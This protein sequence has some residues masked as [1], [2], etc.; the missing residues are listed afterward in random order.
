M[1]TDKGVLEYLEAGEFAALSDSEKSDYY[2]SLA[3][4]RRNALTADAKEA[5]AAAYNE[6]GKYRSAAHFASERK[7]EAA[8]QREA[9][10][11]YMAERKKKG[12][13]VIAIICAVLF[14]LIAAV[15]AVSM[16]D[17]KGK[18]YAKA[19]ELYNAGKYSEAMVIFETIRNYEDS[20]LY[21]SSINGMIMTGTIGNQRARVGDRVT[22]GSWYK[23]GDSSAEK[24]GIEWI[25]IGV[26]QE[27]KQAFLISADIL[28]AREF[29]TTDIWKN[30]EILQWLNGD[31]LNGAFN[32]AE[33]AQ[34]DTRLYGEYDEELESIIGFSSKVAL[35][36]KAEKDEYLTNVTDLKAE[37]AG[38]TEWWLRTPANE[39]N[40]V[41]VSSSGQIATVGKD[42]GEV[43]G[44]RPVIWVDFD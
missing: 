18:Q 17:T 21:I 39:G 5:V 7:T 41:Y 44:I 10:A 33:K 15:A 8:K 4:E 36:S 38:Q 19:V 12:I 28:S 42:S 20:D 26:D 1:I 24:E 30:T 22:F 11:A 16:I 13:K 23:D 29:G 14:V 43:L 37:G 2:D 34:I 25:V 3:L 32:S 9:D 35:L 31:F 40:I 27:K 6:L